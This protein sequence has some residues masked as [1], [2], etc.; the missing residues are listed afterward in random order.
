M[1]WYDAVLR[2][3]SPI[4][5]V[6]ALVHTVISAK[7]RAAKQD[8]DRLEKRLMRVED[9]ADEAAGLSHRVGTLEQNRIGD[10]DVVREAIDRLRT[11]TQ[12]LE[13][14]LRHMPT[15]DHLRD[16]QVE[17]A[18]LGGRIEALTERLQPLAMMA[19]RMQDQV[20]KDAQR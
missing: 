16:V 17:I 18:R 15:K 5:A 3:L 13:E 6:A 9:K 4:V 7:S 19:S 1:E 12:S 8:Q 20:Q 2:L 14:N 11:R 10:L